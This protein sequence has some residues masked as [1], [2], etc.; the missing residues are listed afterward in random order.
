EETMKFYTPDFLERFGSEDE[1]IALAAH[2]ELER[3][4]EEYSQHVEEIEGKL[5]QRFR[6]L[7]NQFY[8]HDARVI[9]HPPLMITDVEWLERALRAGLSLGWRVFGPRESRLPSYWIPLELDTPPRE[10]LV[11]QYRGVQIENVEIHESIFD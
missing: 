9:S 8:L 7:L 11:L 5:P 1:D 10:I 3:R 6:D 4:S 2:D